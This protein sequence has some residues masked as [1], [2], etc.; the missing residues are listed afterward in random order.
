M[1]A[2]AIH[3]HCLEQNLPCQAGTLL[4]AHFLTCCQC[5]PVTSIILV[6]KVKISENYL[7]SIFAKTFIQLSFVAFPCLE[8]TTNILRYSRVSTI[9]NQI[10]IPSVKVFALVPEPETS[11]QW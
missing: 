1:L 11:F 7:Q 10:F 8:S 2:K 5:L 6:I 9:V 4:V 3:R